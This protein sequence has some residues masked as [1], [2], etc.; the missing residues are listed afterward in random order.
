MCFDLAEL[1]KGDLPVMPACISWPIEDDFF[2]P[3]PVTIVLLFR[4]YE[5]SPSSTAP[6][7]CNS[8]MDVVMSL[9]GAC[10]YEGGGRCDEFL[11]VVYYFLEVWSPV[12]S[13]LVP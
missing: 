7:S 9:G 4:F 1:A 10:C 6:G 2:P 5:L 12:V 3:A 11:E 13:P 8:I